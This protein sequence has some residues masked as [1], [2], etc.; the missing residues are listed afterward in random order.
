MTWTIWVAGYVFAALF[1]VRLAYWKD[2]RDWD[3]DYPGYAVPDRPHPSKV[4]W[5]YITAGALWPLAWTAVI[6]MALFDLVWKTAT[7][8]LTKKPTGK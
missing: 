3:Q 7:M 6:A 8:G 1:T 2:C 4:R 5:P